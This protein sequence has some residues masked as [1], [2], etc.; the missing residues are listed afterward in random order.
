MQLTLQ[1]KSNKNNVLHVGATEVDGLN[2]HYQDQAKVSLHLR[3][4]SL[5][6]QV[7]D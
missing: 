2:L 1:T 5:Q 3:K 7:L 4:K 6:L